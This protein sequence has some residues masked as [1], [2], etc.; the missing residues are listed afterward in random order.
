VSD[1]IDI[2]AAVVSMCFKPSTWLAVGA[3]ALVALMVGCLAFK[4]I[5]AP[6]LDAFK[7]ALTLIVGAW[8]IIVKDVFKGEE[9]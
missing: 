1:K 5:P 8:I 3:T 6:Q 2:P 7:T 4:T 9:S